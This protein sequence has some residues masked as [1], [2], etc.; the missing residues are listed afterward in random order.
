MLSNPTSRRGALRAV[1]ALLAGTP[2]LQSQAAPASPA[3]PAAPGLVAPLRIGGTGSATGGVQLVAEAYRRAQPRQPVQ[4]LT[5][6]GS[7]GGI[8]ALSAG[9]LDVALSNR[10]PSDAE[11]AAFEFDAVEY[12]RT[13]FVIAVHRSLGVS[14]L[15]AAELARLF[16]PGASFAGGQRARP[17]LRLA[18]ATD[19]RLLH[20]FSPAVAAAA[21]A[22]G[23]RRGM[24][25]AATDADAA[26]QLQNTPGA[27]GGSTL[28]QILSE[29]RPLVALTIDG[30]APTLENLA[31]GT[32]PQHKRLFAITAKSPTPAVA[33]FMAFLR[34]AAMQALLKA[35]GHLPA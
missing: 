30:R 24:L 32:Y 17:V 31:S 12:A 26:D 21:E 15:S 23:T 22:A 2:A 7:A 16:E 34:S 14:A 11:R 5:A 3:A 28:A 20:S 29:K 4:V 25:N 8:Q 13:P 6:M 35:H 10:A 27:F 18:D 9:R 1:A 33:G 19:T